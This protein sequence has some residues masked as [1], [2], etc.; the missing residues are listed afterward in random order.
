MIKSGFPPGSQY[1]FR[2]PRQKLVYE[3]DTFE[4]IVKAYEGMQMEAAA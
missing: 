3:P 2:T 1:S 4:N